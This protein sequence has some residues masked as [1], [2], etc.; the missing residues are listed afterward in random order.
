MSKK[1][2][3]LGL[4]LSIIGVAG[5]CLLSKSKD[6]KKAEKFE[7]G[8]ENFTQVV[9]ESEKEDEIV[10]SEPVVEETTEESSTESKPE[11]IKGYED[12]QESVKDIEE[13]SASSSIK[14]DPVWELSYDADISES[15]CMLFME[16]EGTGAVITSIIAQ[17]AKREGTVVSDYTV[18]IATG[19]LWDGKDWYYEVFHKPTDKVYK[20]VYYSDAAGRG[21]YLAE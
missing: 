19:A 7:S 16:D 21:G 8:Y 4:G 6:D 12:Y 1:T 2:V 10:V 3:V 15:V 20:V 13:V 9:D 14:Y 11:V 18:D 17:L 5:V